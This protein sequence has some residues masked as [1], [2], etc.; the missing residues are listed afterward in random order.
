M[1]NG[2]LAIY[3]AIWAAGWIVSYLKGKRRLAAI[4]AVPVAVVVVAGRLGLFDSANPA[5]GV[6]ASAMT[7]V[8]LAAGITGAVARAKP[9]SWWAE[10]FGQKLPVSS[11]SRPEAIEYWFKVAT[12][13][14]TGIVW[15]LIV[16][17]IILPPLSTARGSNA[18]P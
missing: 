1:K 17:M 15:G 14:F 13:W 9:G 7:M 4:V 18:M 8:L 12:W 10:R 16:M 11:M 6:I 2:I 3:V 5:I